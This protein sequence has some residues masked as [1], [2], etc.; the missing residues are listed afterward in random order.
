MKTNIDAPDV[1]DVDFDSPIFDNATEDVDFE[2]PTVVKPKP[3]AAAKP[4]P[5]DDLLDLDDEGTL[6]KLGGGSF[7]RIKP[8]GD[9]WVR[10]TLAQPAI[11]VKTHLHPIKRSPIACLGKD[12]PCCQFLDESRDTV[13]VLSIAYP[14]ADPRTGALRKGQPVEIQAAYVSLSPSAARRMKDLLPEGTSS[15]F[16]PDWKMKKKPN[17]AVGYEFAVQAPVAAYRQLG[18]EKQAQ[19]LLAPY[20]DGKKLRERLARTMTALEIKTLAKGDTDPKLDDPAEM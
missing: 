2:K 12:A 1:V 6:N 10:F 17:G 5:E 15:I 13:G 11:L 4:K 3:A 20:R 7:R 19:E 14:A 8:E 9:G 18:L 16:T